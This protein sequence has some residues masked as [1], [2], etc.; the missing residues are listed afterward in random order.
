LD[1]SRQEEM[2]WPAFDSQEQEMHVALG[3]MTRNPLLVALSATIMQSVG[4]FASY[5]GRTKKVMNQVISDW[6]EIINC[7]EAKNAKATKRLIAEHIHKWSKSYKAEAK[8]KI[9]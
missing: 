3:R 5:I 9:V 2:D 4:H 7:L 6:T 1:L 8:N